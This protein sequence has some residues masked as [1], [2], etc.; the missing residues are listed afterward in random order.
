MTVVSA[1]AVVHSSKLLWY[2]TRGSGLVVT[3]FLTAS[4]VLGI[5]TTVRVSAEGWPRFVVAA[6][7]RNISLFALVGLVLH[8]GTAVL[9]SYAPIG[10]LDALLPLH[11]GYRALWVGF[12]AVAFDLMLA[13]LITSLL[14]V[15]LG[16]DRWRAV[17]WLAYGSWAAAIFHGLGTGSDTKVGWVL[18][19]YAGC[20]IAVL[21]AFGWRL[22][23]GWPAQ[24]RLRV[25]AGALAVVSVTALTGWVKA[26]PLQPGWALAAGTPKSLIA[27]GTATSGSGPAPSTPPDQALK[28]AFTDTV[29][30]TVNQGAVGG[31]GLVTISLNLATSG[32]VPGRLAIE[33]TGQPSAGGGVEE[34]GSRVTF[35]PSGSSRAWTGSLDTL[36]GNRLGSVVS[37]GSSRLRLTL[38][39]TLDRTSGAVSG[40]L[41][42]APA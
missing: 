39:I 9:D 23:F 34:T 38:D 40:R 33:I 27:G 3:V 22:T 11:S 8:I 10:W 29:N 25:A 7:H 37:R 36:D 30:G 6:L 15:R 31:A 17:H 4:V 42:G 26:G 41:A 18:G 2:L 24:R 14:R 12:G 13:V 21:A 19:I 32:S 5:L 20:V 16:Y 35:R 1:A 28:S